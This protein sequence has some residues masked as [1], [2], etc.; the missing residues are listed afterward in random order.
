MAL[1]IVATL[2]L[3]RPGVAPKGRAASQT[4]CTCLGSTGVFPQPRAGLRAH[5]SGDPSPISAFGIVIEMPEE[6]VNT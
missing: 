2:R 4:L 6:N 5:R 1:A 3:K